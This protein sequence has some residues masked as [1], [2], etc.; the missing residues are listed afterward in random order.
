MGRSSIF[1]IILGTFAFSASSHAKVFHLKEQ[2]AGTYLQAT[3]GTSLL[4]D[5]AYSK[6]DVTFENKVGYNMS[7]EFGFMFLASRTWIRLGVALLRPQ[8]IEGAQA[9]DT[10][11]AVL[12]RLNSGIIAFGPVMSF[13]F[14]IKVF[15][16]TRFYFMGGLGYMKVTVKNDYQFTAAGTTA[17][18]L[19]DY[20]EE[21]SAYTWMS[22][23]GIGMELPLADASTFILNTGYRSLTANGLKHERSTPAIGGAIDS[24][25]TLKDS[26]GQ[27][28]NLNL[29]SYWVG[30]GLRFYWNF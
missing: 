11:D 18:S 29:S 2:T 26:N 3:G 5:T 6:S 21:A 15:E 13:E 30:I 22:E 10:S 4:N 9:K 16:S 17:Y 27:D 12:Y 19:A 8:V 25:D 20:T 7:G 14:P 24:G 1:G 23:V 28:R